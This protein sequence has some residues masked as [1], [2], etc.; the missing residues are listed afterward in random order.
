LRH[1]VFD[2]LVRNRAGTVGLLENLAR[3]FAF[4]KARQANVLDEPAEGAIFRGVQ[5]VGANR[6]FELYLRGCEAS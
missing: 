2:R 5:L 4:A 6:N 3:H 1:D